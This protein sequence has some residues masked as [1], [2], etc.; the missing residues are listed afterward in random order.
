[1]LNFYVDLFLGP[2]SFEA[3]HAMQVY[4]PTYMYF[5]ESS[6]NHK[7]IKTTAIINTLYFLSSV[8]LH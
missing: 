4:A 1:M 8:I 2:R 7:Q 5:K 6:R 3:K